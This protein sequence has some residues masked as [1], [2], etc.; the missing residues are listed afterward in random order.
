MGEQTGIQILICQGTGGISAGAKKVELGRTTYDFVQPEEVAQI[1]DEHI[2]KRTPMEKRKAKPYYNTFVD[3]QMRV[4][5]TGCGQIDPESLEAYL[6]EEGFKA[7]EKCVKDMKPAEVVE[8]VK[9]S[10]LRGR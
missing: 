7:I 1:V 3:S 10:G 2:V 8:E 6:A 9:K 4:V 5:M